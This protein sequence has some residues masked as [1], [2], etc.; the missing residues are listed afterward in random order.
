MAESRRGVK[1]RSTFEKD[2][3]TCALCPHTITF[4]GID[5]LLIHAAK[6]NKDRPQ[7]HRGYFRALK[8]ALKEHAEIQR[9]QLEAQQ[10]EQPPQAGNIRPAIGYQKGKGGR[11]DTAQNPTAGEFITTP[12]TWLFVVHM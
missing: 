12:L 9:E 3:K 5:A 2:D 10:P 6:Y 8:E 4:K 1:R 7:Q 11:P